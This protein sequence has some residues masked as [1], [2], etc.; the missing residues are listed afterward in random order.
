MV[1]LDHTRYQ[2]SFNIGSAYSPTMDGDA[3]GNSAEP[4][5]ELSEQ[6]A[7]WLH[8]NFLQREDVGLRRSH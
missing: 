3:G 8:P 6:N 7:A 5:G 4:R 2:V 1:L